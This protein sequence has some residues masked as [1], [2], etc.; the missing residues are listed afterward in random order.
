MGTL[1][2]KVAYDTGKHTAG[3]MTVGKLSVK[4]PTAGNTKLKGIG[5]VIQK[6]RNDG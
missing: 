1:V 2:K 6:L 5:C 3:R 4:K